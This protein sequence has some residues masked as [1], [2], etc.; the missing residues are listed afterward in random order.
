MGVAE[1]C[2]GVVEDAAAGRVQMCQMEESDL[3]KAIRE[4]SGDQNGC[5]IKQPFWSPDDSRIAFLKSDSSIWH[6][7][8][9]PAAASS[10]T[11]TQLSATPINFLD[12]WSDAHTLLGANASS[13]F[14][15]SDDGGTS[16]TISAL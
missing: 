6:I 8:T 12:G 9:L 13:F 14:W 4:S 2:V 3:R 11:P 1:S 10:T 15:I 16:Q 7:W 5:L